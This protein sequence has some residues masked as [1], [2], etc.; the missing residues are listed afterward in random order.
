MTWSG[1]LKYLDSGGPTFSQ[2]QTFSWAKNGYI[3]KCTYCRP[4]IMHTPH[5]WNWS[6]TCKWFQKTAEQEIFVVY[7][8]NKMWSQHW[9]WLFTD[10]TCFFTWPHSELAKSPRWVI[11][12]LKV[13]IIFKLRLMSFQEVF[14]YSHFTVNKL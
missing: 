2:H 8:S 12:Y 6:N 11:L 14:V 10:V 4:T 1:S 3:W 9:M 13:K 5:L 7:I